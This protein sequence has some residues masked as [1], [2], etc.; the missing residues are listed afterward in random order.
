MVVPT[1]GEAARGI[2]AL[3]ALR[4]WDPVPRA[5][6]H[7]THTPAPTR[8]PTRAVWPWAAPPDGRARR[9]LSHSAHVAAN[10]NLTTPARTFHIWGSKSGAFCLITSLTFENYE[11]SRRV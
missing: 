7:R 3:F 8:P 5:S 4:H 2:A 11:G 10:E 1:V 6:G 9:G